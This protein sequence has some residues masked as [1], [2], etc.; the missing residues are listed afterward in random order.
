MVEYPIT[1]IYR[2]PLL[3]IELLLIFIFMEL[4]IYF[5]SCYLL[6]KKKDVPSVVE[7]DWAI[8]F[9]SFGITYIFYVMGD[10]FAADFRLDRGLF[11][12][13]GYLTLVI[14]GAIFLYHVERSR[15]FYTGYKLAALALS[16]AAVFIGLYLFSP[17]ILQ[18]VG[19]G[20]SFFAFGIIILYFLIIIHKIWYFY[21]IHSIGLFIGI[22]LWIIGY[23]GATDIASEFFGGFFIRVIS[24]LAIIVGMLFVGFFVNSIPSLNTI[25]WQDKIKYVMLITKSG[26]TVYS[27]NFQEHKQVNSVLVAGTLYGIDAFFKNIIKN[28][29]LKV[30]TQGTDVILIEEGELVTGILVTEQN[31]EL[32]HYLLKKLVLQFEF[33][34]LRLLMKWGGDTTLFMPTQF[35]IKK[36]F[37]RL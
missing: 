13:L 6:N 15:T 3:T 18:L 22:F 12:V 19:S 14:G 2:E 24:D 37:V 28:A 4:S 9:G 17:D 20:L 26:V 34:Y 7:L 33:Y 36:I 25:G 21:K 29:K 30:I 16:F 32:F 23:M 35:L 10:F 5:F 27:E 1:G 11:I 8:M 31:L